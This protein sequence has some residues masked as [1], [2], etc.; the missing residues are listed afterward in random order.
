M[1]TKRRIGETKSTG[2]QVGARRTFSVP[3]EH[4]WKVLT[5]PRGTTLWLGPGSPPRF[6]AGE[7]YR[8][9]D[10]SEGEVRVVSDSHLRLT[11]R[12]ATW[13]GASTVQVRV[14]P[15]GAGTVVAFHQEHLPGPAERE[16]RKSFYAA[17]LDGLERML[18]S[19]D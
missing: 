7:R 18:G 17:A 13:E 12:P 4:A 6:A 5:S 19:R 10:G 8:L 2:F 3:P 11:W 1:N 15:R 16:E 9:A 14:I